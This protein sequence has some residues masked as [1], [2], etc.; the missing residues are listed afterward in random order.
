MVPGL[1]VVQSM[2]GLAG[3]SFRVCDVECCYQRRRHPRPA[4]HI[5][6]GGA[7]GPV[8][9]PHVGNR[10]DS[11]MSWTSMLATP[12]REL[13]AGRRRSV[14]MG[15]PRVRAAATIDRCHRAANVLAGDLDAL[16]PGA[17][18]YG[19]LATQEDALREV[20]HAMAGPHK[21][22]IRRRLSGPLTSKT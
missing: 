14:T 20:P 21:L 4:H 17:D 18:E 22:Q 16:A 19:G 2:V 13:G 1:L 11:T 10:S 7:E 6:S 15:T 12:R 8:Y 5:D 9:H 3:L